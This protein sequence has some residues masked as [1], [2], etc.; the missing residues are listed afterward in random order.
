[1]GGGGLALGS[2][3]LG[4]DLG[5][6]GG[7]SA[8]LD[9][10]GGVGDFRHDADMG[11]ALVVGVQGI[12]RAGAGFA[13]AGALASPPE[14]RTHLRVKQLRQEYVRALKVLGET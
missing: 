1:M 10:R 2:G 13:W 12:L 9:G 7:G 6:I 3:D 11:G 4:V 14:N 8:V 5:A